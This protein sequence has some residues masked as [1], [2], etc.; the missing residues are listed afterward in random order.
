M[1][2]QANVDATAENV[3]FLQYLLG[4]ADESEGSDESPEA[5]EKE[6]SEQPQVIK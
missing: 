1:P 5:A 2:N 4:V 3:A 6:V